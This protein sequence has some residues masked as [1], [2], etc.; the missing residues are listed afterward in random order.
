MKISTE[1]MSPAA[2]IEASPP[3]NVDMKPTFKSVTD[4]GLSSDH[5]PV[6]HR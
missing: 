6:L 1:Y 2:T 3:V 4:H 5:C